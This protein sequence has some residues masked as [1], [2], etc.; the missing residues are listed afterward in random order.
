[1][2]HTKLFEQFINEDAILDKIDQLQIFREQEYMTLSK[3]LAI[4]RK[5]SEG[6]QAIKQDSNFGKGIKM[7]EN[8]KKNSNLVFQ[9]KVY[10]SEWNYGGNLVVTITLKGDDNRNFFQ[11]NSNN[12]TRSPQYTFGSVF[13]GIRDSEGKSFETGSMYGSYKSISNFKGVM[14]DVLY[15]FGDYARV[16]GNDFDLKSAVK[17]QK[18]G[19]K[20]KAEW[21]KAFTK[22]DKI[23][24]EAKDAA[25]VVSREIAM[26]APDLRDNNSVIFFKHDEPRELRHPDEY[27]DRADMM[28]STKAYDKYEKAISKVSDLCQ[29]FADKHK[30]KF[31][32][33]ASY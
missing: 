8:L 17:I 28:M 20:L 15:A 7:A 26:R 27:G 22:I 9:A 33:A 5:S 4:C 19:Q 12:S 21:R 1:M 30:I 10:R 6:K 25:R 14:S 29:K 23:Y 18:A 16:N 31:I 3:F 24:Y 11:F 32:W 13:K 2:K